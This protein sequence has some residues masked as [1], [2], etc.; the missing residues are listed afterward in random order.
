MTRFASRLL[1]STA[2][3]ALAPMAFADLTAEDVWNDWQFYGSSFGYQ[4]S[5]APVRDGNSLVVTDMVMTAQQSSAQGSGSITLDR[6]VFQEQSDGSVSISFPKVMPMDMTMQTD[7]GET[8][9]IKMDYLQTGLQMNVSGTPE[10]MNYSYS[11]ETVTL[12]TN[13]IIVE[14][15]SPEDEQ[16]QITVLM[17]ALDGN[18]EMT[19]DAKRRYDQNV[20]VEQVTYG[21][22]LADPSSDE[23]LALNGDMQDISFAGNT[24]LPLRAMSAEDVD[25]ML[26]A[27][28]AVD[29]TFTFGP[30]AAEIVGTSPEGPFSSKVSSQEGS[31]GV[32]MNA[33]ILTYDV[34]QSST[35]LEMFSS[36]MPLPLSFEMAQTRLQISMPVRESDTPQNFALGLELDGFTM[37]DILWG[38][39][40]PT[41]QLPRDPATIAL[42]VAGKARLL[43]NVLSPDA[44][45]LQN[46]TIEGAPVEV[47]N[48]DINKLQIA[49]AGAD[50]TGAGGFKFDNSGDG[51]PQPVGAVDLKLVGGNA[52]IDKLVAI[53]LVPEQQAM[54]ARMMLGLLAVPGDAPDTLNSKIEINEQ[55]HVSANGQRIQ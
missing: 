50:L 12:K 31:V 17:E 47:E 37:S 35:L 10:N 15:L 48:V 21:F 49:V 45:E 41:S 24:E 22:S 46:A 51:A 14:G 33:D 44:E 8:L 13:T 18:T 40:D 5:G 19:L 28:F 4:V 32:K 52:L 55:G 54:G 25:A 27:G 20:S 2:C 34:A 16:P 9:S 53:G 26:A 30:N 6:V 36:Q 23:R 7:E 39:F 3:I 11:A 43:F 1:A 42:D 29:G 38:M